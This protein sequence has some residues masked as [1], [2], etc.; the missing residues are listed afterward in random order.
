M[1]LTTASTFIVIVRL[2]ALKSRLLE[3]SVLGSEMTSL[4]DD[5]LHVIGQEP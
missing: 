1:Y 4:C 2:A 5:C 3:P